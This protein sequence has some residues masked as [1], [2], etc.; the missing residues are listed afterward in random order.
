[1]VLSRDEH[2]AS[3]SAIDIA[4]DMLARDV[5]ARGDVL[6]DARACTD[7]NVGGSDVGR[8]PRRAVD[9]RRKVVPRQRFRV[10]GVLRAV[11]KF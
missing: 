6:R 3:R 10:A 8:R 9:E 4:R 1:M 11:R 7:A 5:A 2:A